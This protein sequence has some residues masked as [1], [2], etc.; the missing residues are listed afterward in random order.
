MKINEKI[1]KCPTKK[2]TC[3]GFEFNYGKYHTDELE[4]NFAKLKEETREM[5]FRED[6]LENIANTLD[7]I[8]N[9]LELM[10]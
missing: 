4:I 5:L 8:E 10:R 9:K 1:V 2:F 7:R 6:S 3:V